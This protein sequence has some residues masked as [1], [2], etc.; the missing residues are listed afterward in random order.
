MLEAVRQRRVV[1]VASWE[2]ATEIARTL[3]RPKLRKYRLSEDDVTEALAF[4][5]PFL[6]TVDLDVTVRDPKDVSVIRSALL[7]QAEAIVTGDRDLLDDDALRRR[8][9]KRGIRIMTPK[10]LLTTLSE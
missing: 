5:A 1:P 2:L 3:R 6:P 7:G 9:G 8:L 10:E 4:L